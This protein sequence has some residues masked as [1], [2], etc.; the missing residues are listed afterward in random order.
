MHWY[1]KVHLSRK[2]GHYWYGVVVTGRDL[3]E[4]DL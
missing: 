1:W 2:D 3:Q 4:I